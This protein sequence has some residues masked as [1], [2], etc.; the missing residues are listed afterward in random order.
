MKDMTLI[1]VILDRSGSME[2]LAEEAVG[3]FNRFLDDQ[4]TL[5]DY[6]ELSLIQFDDLYEENYLR[7]PIKDCPDLIP[8][9]TYKPRGMTALYDAVGKS[10]NTI[11]ENLK[12]LSSEERPERILFVIIT[13]G[14][15]N[16]SKEFTGK[17]IGEMIS[18]Q[19]EVY[20]W[21]FI[22]LAAG[23]DAI[24]EG[25]KF[26]VDVSKCSSVSFDEDGVK[27]VGNTMS[28]YTT[29]YRMSGDTSM[30]V[31]DF[32]LMKGGGGEEE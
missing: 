12:A 29:S 6:A 3:M 9:E 24:T 28:N 30:K 7:M 4:K 21:D 32:N 19:K 23:I 31:E 16:A 11:G 13:D 8:W 10:I 20:N 14:Y 1:N 27:N 25:M 17:V 15:E 2:S 22:F 5:P 18:H 26:G